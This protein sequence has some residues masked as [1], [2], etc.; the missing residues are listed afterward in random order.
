MTDWTQ[1]IPLEYTKEVSTFWR[2][3]YDWRLAE[4]AINR[5]PQFV[6]H[7]DDLEI[8]F[9]HRVLNRSTTMRSPCLPVAA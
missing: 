7:L 8:Y 6:T 9:Q 2:E 3:A 1:G 4:A 5:F